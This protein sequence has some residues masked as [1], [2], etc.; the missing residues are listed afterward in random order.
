MFEKTVSEKLIQLLFFFNCSTSLKN[1][2]IKYN[3]FSSALSVKI[4]VLSKTKK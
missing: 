3:L 1:D 2:N 4:V